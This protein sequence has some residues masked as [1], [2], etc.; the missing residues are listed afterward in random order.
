MRLRSV[1]FLVLYL[2]M[3]SFASAFEVPSQRIAAIDAADADDFDTALTLAAS[4]PLTRDIVQWIILRKGHDDFAEYQT[5]LQRRPDW[6]GQDR[7]R[8]R[9]EEAMPEGLPPEDVIAWFADQP[10]LT[11]E[12]T[13]H[14]VEA[15]LQLEQGEDALLTLKTAWMDLRLTVTGFATLQ[16]GFG[17]ILERYHPQRVD[18]LL[19]RW[20]VEDARKMLP[21]LD[22]DQEALARAR[23]GYIQNTTGLSDL[24]A[25]VPETLKDHP[26][27][28]YDRYSWLAKRGRKQEAVDILL[29]R[30]AELGE[31]F[32]WSGWRRSLARWD[33]REGRIDR[34]YVLAA[35]HG[36]QEGQAY[37]DLEWLAGYISLYYR[38]EPRQALVHFDRVAAAV[39]SPIS[40]G[41][42]GYWRARAYED[43]DDMTAARAAYGEAAQHQTGFYGLLAADALGLALDPRL[44]G[45]A[46]PQ[47]WRGA[48]VMTQDL[49]QAALA[50]LA[51]GDRTWAV[52]FF[53]ELGRVLPAQDIAQLSAY[54]QHI[55]DPYFAV[56]LGKAAAARG[57]I[58][59]SAYFPLHEMKDMDLPVDPALALAIARRESEFS[60]AA[61]SPV[62]ALGMMQLMPAT[63]QEMAGFVGLPY[64]KTRLTQDWQ[65]NVTLGARY[66]QV[67]QDQFGASPAQITAG[68][69]AGPSRP[70]GWMDRFGDPRVG[71]IDVVD[72]IEHI[73]FRETRNYVM[74]VTEAIPVYRARLQ[75]EGGPVS[76]HALLTGQKP[77][78]RPVARDTELSAMPEEES[79]SL[80]SQDGAASPVARPAPLPR[81]RPIPRA[82][83]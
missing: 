46:D 58:V 81:V 34:A 28:A 2:N 24:V 62:G 44:T 82:G 59:P 13:R 19:W 17:D 23:I 77:L 7:L 37:A 3:A 18:A 50:F 39:D 66:L 6:P 43:L 51:A 63:A 35:E 47:E 10:P 80:Q 54:L 53:A 68:Y 76:F 11:G 16:D 5:H 71:E 1:L 78:I 48:D 20:R 79:S 27:L 32:R 61:G 83:E 31:P 45:A 70:E 75:Q 72:W 40:L 14:L 55:N 4:D 22:E 69:N 73:P 74:R 12:G 38:K 60:I 41:R 8:A 21:L 52:T 56:L 15:Y 67:L 30:E 42:A 49:T 9:A 57:I 26:G 64:A 36:L 33:M 29:A 25:S 65:Y